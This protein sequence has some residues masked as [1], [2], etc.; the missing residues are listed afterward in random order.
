LSK[1]KGF[2]NT[3][4]DRYSLALYELAKESNSLTQVE[5]NSDALLDLISN[6]KNFKNF[7]KDPSISRDILISVIS[8]ISAVSKLDN[9]FNNFL[10][11]LIIKRRF[12]F[13]EQI[14]KSFIEICSKK[15]GE[16]KAE[17]K[18]AK[19]L[20]EDEISRITK[21]LSENFKSKIKLNYNH[22]ESLIGG[23]IVQVGS[24]MIDTS[25][26]NRLQQIENK[27]LKA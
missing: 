18:S 10:N 1:N 17:I 8:K 24:T 15:R 11:F 23:L 7:I 27:M 4:A 14:L 26:K 2:S 9:L 25:I 19:K 5:Q 22:D 3:S 16:L 12:F 13:V 21:E 6:D 20:T